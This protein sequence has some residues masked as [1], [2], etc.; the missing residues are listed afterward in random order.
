MKLLFGTPD[1]VF[2]RDFA[3]YLAIQILIWFKVVVTFF[4]FGKGISYFGLPIAVHIPF[5]SIP[6]FANAYQV[7]EWG[8]HFLMHFF[9]AAWVFLLVKHLKKTVLHEL[10][11]LGGL[12]VF[13]HNVAYWFT[14]SHASWRFSVWDLLV[15]YSALALF[16]ILFWIVL[17]VFPSLQK[18]KIPYLE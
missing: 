17:R 16:F 8:F 12:A 10:I 5:S 13:L 15:D 2:V 1:K 3:F 18:M 11:F 14:R 4:F 7:W 9:I 6:Y